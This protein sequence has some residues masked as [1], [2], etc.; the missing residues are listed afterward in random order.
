MAGGRTFAAVLLT[1]AACG[2]PKTVEAGEGLPR[3]DVVLACIDGVGVEHLAGELPAFAK[4]AREGV[5]FTAAHAPSPWAGESLAALLTGVVAPLPPERGARAAETG[6]SDDGP[7]T[8]SEVLE[9][10]GYRTAFLPAHPLHLSAALERLD[11][12]T[13]RP[14]GF[15][16]VLEAPG[17]ATKAGATAA[18]VGRV[19]EAWL[20]AQEGPALLVCCFADPAPPHHLYGDAKAA[21]LDPAYAG[22]VTSG[23]SHSEL[24]RRAPS[25]AEADRARL[26]ALHRSEVAAVEL[27]FDALAGVAVDRRTRPPILAV[28]GLRRP[29]LGEDGRYG[30]VPSLAPEDL[31]V[32]LLLRLSTGVDGARAPVGAT[33]TPVSLVDLYPT[34]LDALG[35][36]A[37]LDLDG[38]SVFPGARSPERTIV[39]RTGRGIRGE[40]ILGGGD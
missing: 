7:P 8:L 23:L 2:G 13:G 40:V 35:L 11:D 12:G 31:R 1:A 19:A 6:P 4:M 24:L 22:P 30:L 9:H 34:L 39:A 37:R 38:R 3:P 26:R 21:G 32:P 15:H 25:F 20:R 5:V 10:S 33:S 36:P 17:A 27:A 14:R 18:D 29:A 16:V 28:A